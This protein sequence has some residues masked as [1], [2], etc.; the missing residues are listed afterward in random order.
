MASKTRS[1]KE[2]KDNLNEKQ[3][4]FAKEYLVDLN[5]SKAALRAGY[6]AASAY[7]Q[8]HELLKNEFVQSVIQEE[9]DKRAAKVDL[10]AEKVLTEILKLATSD[11][12]K[13]FDDKGG[14][15]P[16]EKWPDDVAASVSSIEI[17]ELFDGFGQDR[18]QIGFTKK[19]RLWD[20]TKSL[21]LLGRHLKLFTDK[22]EVEG[23]LSIA[24]SMRKARERAKEK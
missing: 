9:M 10:S 22:L 21:E 2:I 17:D 7:N 16:P 15:L 18:H 8:G 12:R 24:E 5:A 11:L 1:T 14:L 6:A 13:L 4:L 23:D 19:V 20:K 3:R